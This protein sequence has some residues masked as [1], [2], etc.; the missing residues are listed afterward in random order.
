MSK[1][2]CNT[3]PFDPAHAACRA[4]KRDFCSSCLVYSFGPR[5]PPFCVPCALA[6]AGVRRQGRR[7]RLSA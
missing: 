4:C 7:T 1:V 5:K 3:H 2:V 6:A